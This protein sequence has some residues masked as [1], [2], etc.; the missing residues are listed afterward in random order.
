MLHLCASPVAG[1]AARRDAM[2][3]QGTADTP[4]SDTPPFNAPERKQALCEGTECLR[5]DLRTSVVEVV[6]WDHTCDLKRA[7]EGVRQCRWAQREEIM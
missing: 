3:C 4:L 1:P 5:A 7:F 6:Y 2:Y